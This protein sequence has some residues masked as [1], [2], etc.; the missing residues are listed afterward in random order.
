MNAWLPESTTRCPAHTHTHI[1]TQYTCTHT[2]IQ[3]IYIYTLCVYTNT[4]YTHTHIHKHTLYMHKH[5]THTHTYT[6]IHIIHIYTHT[7]KH[8]HPLRDSLCSLQTVQTGPSSIS[9]PRPW[10]PG[11]GPMTLDLL[12]GFSK[13]DLREERADLPPW[14]RTVK[15]KAQL[16]QPGGAQPRPRRIRKPCKA[17][18]GGGSEGTQ[19]EGGLSP[20]FLY[21][22]PSL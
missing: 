17:E 20:G 14:L 18:N 22:E 7:Y 8:T 6:Q 12:E 13:L 19:R 3:I 16:A 4:H 1:L 11:G 2:H 15:L 10:S 21:L 9:V 5:C